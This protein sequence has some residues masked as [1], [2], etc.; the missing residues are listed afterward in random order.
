MRRAEVASL[1]RQ[2]VQ[3]GWAHE[4]LVIGKGERER[5]VYFGEDA[6]RATRA[7]SRRWANPSTRLSVL[8]SARSKVHGYARLVAHSPCV[9][10]RLREKDIA[11]TNFALSAVIHADAHPSRQD[12]AR[13]RR[14]TGVGFGQRLDVLRPTPPRL[15]GA[16]QDSRAT[17]PLAANGRVSSGR[18][19]LLISMLAIGISPF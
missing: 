17:C 12:V 5:H 16:P 19:K 18:S 7:Y 13:V 11:R 9:V 3:D 10:P 8:T 2:N 14:L 1:N 6:Q 4:A 15:K